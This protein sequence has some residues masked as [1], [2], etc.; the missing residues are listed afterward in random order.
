[1]F[2]RRLGGA[3]LLCGLLLLASVSAAIACPDYVCA[4][5]DPFR[6]TVTRG[7]FTNIYLYPNPSSQTWDQYTS[8]S[9]QQPAGNL[10]MTVVGIDQV[11]EALTTSSYFSLLTQYHEIEPPRF[12]G[13]QNTVQQCVDKVMTYAKAN[14]FVLTREILADFVGCEKS[15]GGNPSDQ[16]NIILSPEFEVKADLAFSFP[17]NINVTVNSPTPACNCQGANCAPS[18]YSGETAFHSAQLGTPNF[19]VIPTRCNG[20]LDAV[21]TGI[22]HE[23][24]EMISN[25]ADMGYFHVDGGG[26]Q[27]LAIA[28]NPKVLGTGELSDIC[29]NGGLKNP[30]DPTPSLAYVPIPSLSTPS[31]PVRAARYW[32]NIDKGGDP[33]G[34]CQP[35]FIMTD[36]LVNDS[37]P[38]RMGTD[39]GDPNMQADVTYNAPFLT[40]NNTKPQQQQHRSPSIDPTRTVQQLMLYASTH[41]D[42]LCNESDLSVQINLTAGQPIVFDHVNAVQ[43]SDSWDNNEVH[44]VNL[45]LRPGLLKVSDIASILLHDQSGH[46]Q[47]NLPSGTVGNASG[48]DGWNPSQIIIYAALSPGAPTVTAINPSSGPATGQAITITGTNFIGVS[49]VLIGTVPAASFTVNSNT[50]ITAAVPALAGGAVD[51]TTPQGTGSGPVYNPYPVIT[52]VTPASGPIRGGTI[53]TVSGIGMPNS[54]TYP[55][56]FGGVATTASCG[57]PAGQCAI[58]SPPAAKAGTVDIT[59][60]GSAP[61]AADKFTYVAPTITSVSPKEGSSAGGETALVAGNGFASNMTFKFGSQPAKLA[62]LV[63]FVGIPLPTPGSDSCEVFVPPG[64][65]AV[66]VTGTVAGATST[67]SAADLFTYVAPPTGAMSPNSGPMTG[68]TTVTLTGSNFNTTPGSTTLML[69]DQGV[70][71]KV[72]A[73]CS[74]TKHCQFVTPPFWEPGPAFVANVY[75]TADSIA[76]TLP[77]GFTYT[78]TPEPKPPGGGGGGG[79]SGGNAGGSSCPH[80]PCQ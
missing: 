19:T 40:T 65:G 35:A 25:P 48:L 63:C 60:D 8:Q 5:Q 36:V 43:N 50:S 27:F 55:F 57:Q 52:K 12:S 49:A 34:S 17:G 26:D 32:S 2:I 46:C 9:L 45:P 54:R 73:N 14:N 77:V 29:E 6:H 72:T 11:V 53:V 79:G 51:V 71:A 47:I 56:S 39:G 3:S 18:A 16:V 4:P 23:M 78:P 80:K 30:S 13:H 38:P 15:K 44:A 70:G 75:V 67:Q 21:S 42:N 76:G 20:S 74:T 41:N 64:T 69:T 61:I 33:D 1:M 59:V 37:N 66:H 7:N 68:G 62:A 31:A 24:A 10:P 28:S 58:A 22:S